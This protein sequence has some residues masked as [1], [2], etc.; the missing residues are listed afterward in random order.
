MLY[1]TESDKLRMQIRIVVLIC[2][3]LSVKLLNA[4]LVILLALGCAFLTICNKRAVYLFHN[5]LYCNVMP[6]ALVVFL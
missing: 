2:Y 5:V 1:C 6:S 3:C 4:W